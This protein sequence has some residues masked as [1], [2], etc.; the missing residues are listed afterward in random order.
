MAVAER[1]RCKLS[2]DE[3]PAGAPQKHGDAPLY[4]GPRKASLYSSTCPNCNQP[5][6][7]GDR[8]AHAI[9]F[10]NGCHRKRWIHTACQPAEPGQPEHNGHEH[11][12]D[13]PGFD[14]DARLRIEELGRE[15]EALLDKVADLTA[16]VQEIDARTPRKVEIRVGDRPEVELDE[17]LHPIFDEV[18]TLAA[19]RRNIFLPG[20]TGC[21][22]TH[23]ARQLANA[24]GLP[25]GSVS[26]SGGMSEG[27][28]TGR[29]LPTG[30]SGRFEY[31]ISEFVKCYEG[32]GVFL[33]DEVDAADEN[34]LL[35]INSA[36]ANG[37]MN[38]PNRPEQ[39][40]AERHPDF[41]CIAAANT[42]GTG[43]DRKYVGRNRLDG[44]T[45]DRFRIGV[46]PMD[47]DATL[48]RTLCPDVD[49]LNRLHRYRERIR[50]NKLERDLSTR[51]IVD[52][53]LMTS[54]FGWE[55]E[56]VDAALFTGWRDDEIQKVRG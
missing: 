24:L 45:L 7:R 20:P 41:I 23:L 31:V 12:G 53:Y 4:L 1:R 28:L 16:R 46:V 15:N 6:R 3:V 37:F 48:E 47:Y 52:A 9:I 38:V 40:R 14:A 42:W 36:L 49:L 51:F 54:Q 27:Q 35:A 11:N 29:L 17:S 34:V 8:I 56:R 22:K 32:G 44:A 39:P 5:I 50:A 19:A 13:A 2:P 26:C 21:G 33:L 18:L 30:D 55:Y 43:A 10:R 25:F